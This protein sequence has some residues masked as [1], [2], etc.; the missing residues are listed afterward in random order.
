M[1]GRTRRLPPFIEMH[2]LSPM[3][4][5]FFNQDGKSISISIPHL[6]FRLEEIQ[7]KVHNPQIPNFTISAKFHNPGIPGV[8]AIS[9]CLYIAWKIIVG[10]TRFRHYSSNFNDMPSALGLVFL[11]WL[12]LVPCSLLM[13]YD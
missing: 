12:L 8:R 4:C 11:L 7:I 10:P 5:I 3:F 9:Q 6:I 1:E 2:I 13:F